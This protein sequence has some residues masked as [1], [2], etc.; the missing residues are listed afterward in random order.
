LIRINNLNTPITGQVTDQQPAIAYAFSAEAGTVIDVDL[1]G[2]SGDLDPFALVL[3]S[4]GQEIARND[5]R[6]DETGNSQI[7]GLT[8]SESGDYVVVATRYLGR[9]GFSEGLFELTI[10]ESSDPSDAFGIFPDSLRY[11]TPEEGFI[12]DGTTDHFYTFRGSIGDVISIE[13]RG[14]SNNLDTFLALTDNLG[15]L[16]VINDDNPVSGDTTDALIYNFVLPTDGYYTTIATRYVS[17][18]ETSSG[19]YELEVTL[20]SSAGK[21][22]VY[23]IDGIL[24]PQNSRT[25]RA[26]RQFYTTYVAGDVV[27]ENSREQRLQVLM[28]FSLPPNIS[29]NDVSSASFEFGACF[30][31]GGGFEG[32]GDLTVYQDSYGRLDSGRD[33]T[34]TTTGARIIAVIDQCEPIDLTEIVRG[35]LLGGQSQVQIRLAFRDTSTNGQTD[36]VRFSGPRLLITLNEE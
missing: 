12:D 10:R 32:L 7:R 33:L 31:F 28:T 26:D 35:A 1:I 25:V 36:Q 22:D 11:D 29:S 4:K 5:D 8:L 2:T 27:D 24:D 18:T 19:D 6:G 20:V 30:D 3:T 16:L 17:D 14:A 21:G 23:P 9:F 13:M 15:N 34:R